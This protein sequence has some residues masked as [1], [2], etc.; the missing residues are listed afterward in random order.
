MAGIASKAGLKL[1]FGQ[2]RTDGRTVWVSDIPLNPSEDDYNSVVS[3]LIHE[4]GHIRYTDFGLDRGAKLHALMPALTNVFEDVRIEKELEREFLG[5]RT[6]LAEGYKVAIATGHQRQPDTPANALTMW[7]LLDHMI[8]VNGRSFFTQS[9]NEAYQACLGFGISAELLKDI[10]DL[11]DARVSKLSSTADVI[12][13]SKEVVALLQQSQQEEGQEQQQQSQPQPSQDDSQQESE[14]GDEENSSNSGE[15]ESSESGEDEEEGNGSGSSAGDSDEDGEDGS[16][17]QSSDSQQ[18]S[19]QSQGS[20]S[21]GS[22]E[23]EGDE[24][25]NG[26]STGGAREILESDVEEQSPISLRE[27]AQQVANQASANEITLGDLIGNGEADIANELRQM[28]GSGSKANYYEVE[29]EKNLANYTAIKQEVGKDIHQLKNRLVTRWQNVSRTRE[30]VNEHDGRFS[31]NDAIRCSI[32]GEANYLVKRSKRVDNKPAVCVL[33]DLSGSMSNKGEIDQQARA[34][35]ALTEACD[36]AGIP[37]NI[38]GFST[39]VLNVKNWNSPLAGVRAA[40]GGQMTKTISSTALARAVFEGV[41]TFS[42]RQESKKILI[43]LTDGQV[44]DFQQSTIKNLMAYAEK[45]VSGEIDFYG[46]GIGVDLGNLFPKGGM[47]NP[48]N[49]A[50]SLLEILGK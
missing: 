31:A 37:L 50:H 47:V 21:S 30:C 12:A 49:L 10:E 43:T 44:D 32:S 45:S 16:Q 41:R 23:P 36:Q 8:K 46:L 9:R 38:M 19:G 35:V 3:D 7:L 1:A 26:C 25:G 24:T 40:I 34:L 11:C 42:S 6:F 48:K 4:I 5:A 33:A 13:L 27:L 28:N 14:S 20:N 15:G 39:Y 2:P 29:P 22:S 18:E 17:G